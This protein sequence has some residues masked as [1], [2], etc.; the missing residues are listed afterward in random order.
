MWEI[1][2]L[3]LVITAFAR[4]LR[5]QRHPGGYMAKQMSLKDMLAATP[6][7]AL[8]VPSSSEA[9]EYPCAQ[10]SAMV[11]AAPDNVGRSNTIEA[12]WV[13]NGWCEGSNRFS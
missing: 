5:P 2:D 13:G 3:C 10:P 1:I 8:S 6:S 4:S 7:P 9:D 12:P 11:G